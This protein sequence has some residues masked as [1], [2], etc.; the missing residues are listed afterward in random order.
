MRSANQINEAPTRTQMQL[1]GPG[2]ECEGPGGCGSRVEME[3]EGP[4][5]GWGAKHRR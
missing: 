3:V 4:I 1:A 5:G 2:K